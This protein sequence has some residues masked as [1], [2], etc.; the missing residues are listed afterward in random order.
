MTIA[1]IFDDHP[2]ALGDWCNRSQFRK[3]IRIVGS[4]LR[5]GDG[6]VERADVSLSRHTR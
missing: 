3:M 4:W 5:A 1:F 6:E 2:E